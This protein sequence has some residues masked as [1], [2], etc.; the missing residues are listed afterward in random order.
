[1]FSEPFHSEDGITLNRLF[2]IASQQGLL[3]NFFSPQL[4]DSEFP[5]KKET[6]YLLSTGK[7]EDMYIVSGR[8]EITY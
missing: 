5:L 3:P 4:R 8:L 6:Q 2:R 1:M 7:H